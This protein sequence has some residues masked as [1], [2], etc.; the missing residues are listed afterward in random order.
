MKS[1]IHN[2][3]GKK[4]Q[5]WTMIIGIIAVL[6]VAFY[7]G[8]PLLNEQFGQDSNTSPSSCAD[9][10][11]VITVNVVDALQKGTAVGSPT[12]YASINGQVPTSITSGT[13]TAPI[14]ASVEL[15]ATKADY[16]DAKLES[17][18]MTCG[19]LIETI[20]MFSASSDNPSITIKDDNS[21]TLTDS[22]TGGAN[23]LSAISAGG[24]E[25]VTIELEGTNLESSGDLVMVIETGVSANVSE[26]LVQ[27]ATQLGGIPSVHT[28][29]LAGSK[30]V[31][32]EVPAV[33]GATTAKYP[34]TIVLESGKTI[35]G[36]V[37]TDY[38]AKQWFIDDDGSYKYGIQD[39]DGTAKYENTVDYDFYIT[40]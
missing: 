4:G 39:S 7:F 35:S 12:I 15:F 18:T 3:A 29:Q 9:S 40:A 1:I 20:E 31:A 34:V 2:K 13:S 27:G 6:A 36:A 33:T 24:S 38:Y 11:G 23:N 25:T 30:A 21:D 37:Y 22:A 10:T 5:N 17:K 14:G 28:L 19:G 8:M 26:I 32:Y 16:I